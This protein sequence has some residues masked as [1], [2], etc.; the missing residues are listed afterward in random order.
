MDIRL[1]QTFKDHRKRKRLCAELGPAAVLALV[2][3]WLS[4]AENRPDGNLAG[5]DDTDIELEA[6]WQ[7]Q[8]G[9]L[10]E[11]L[12]RLKFL[13]GET[14]TYR[15]HNWAINQPWIVGFEKRSE[16]G[17]KAIAVRYANR[18][19]TRSI[20]GVKKLATPLPSSPFPSIP[21][22]IQSTPYPA[23]GEPA[24]VEKK[25]K[26]PT[27]RELH[28]EA[29][30]AAVIPA[31]LNTPE[32]IEAWNR[33]NKQRE[34]TKKWQTSGSVELQLKKCEEWGTARAIASLN[35]SIANTYQG[36]FEPSQSTGQQPPLPTV[37]KYRDESRLI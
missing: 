8:N 2:D 4:V 3:L 19:N 24:K 11:S 33:W 32:F 34:D 23:S 30:K 9:R 22:T 35:N 6:N 12:R 26:P 18:Q 36:L 17:K 14:G 15:I 27:R 5:M 16:H 21:N 7:G 10:I 29:V 37:R 31:S 25:V 28:H 20:P 1:N 13:D